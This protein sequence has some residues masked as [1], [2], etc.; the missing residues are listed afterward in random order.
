[1]PFGLK[2]ASNTF[3]RGMTQV[4][5]PVRDFT[6][7]FVDDM[8]VV[9]EDWETHL[10]HLDKYVQI[11]EDTGLTLNLKKCNFAQSKIKFV[12]HIVG[13]GCIEP[14]PSKIATIKDI[15]PPTTKKDVR[16]IMGFFSYFRSFIPALAE[17]TR[18]ITDLTRNDVPSKVPWESKHQQALDKLKE[19]LSKATQL[20]TIDF[21]KDFGLS[22]DASATAVGCCLFQCTASGIE[23]PIAFAS[24]KLSDTQMRWSTIEREAFAVI[25]ALKRF[26]SWI[27][28]SKIN[29]YSDHNPLTYLTEASPKS[30]KLARWAL[31]L[32]E[33]N[34][35]FRYRPGRKNI[36]ADF[37]SRL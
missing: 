23:Q 33:F 22:V 27:F 29:V 7:P 13:S 37:L 19:D 4:L 12:G 18:I 6:E 31:A 14:D 35:H 28:L 17:T 9:S 25:W 32:Q 36:V 15:Q 10:S 26:R 5:Q 21:S 8:A 2:S 24:S 1:M 3:I 30:A 20:H 11:I 16:R 34:V